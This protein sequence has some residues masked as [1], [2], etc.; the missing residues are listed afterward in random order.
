VG[1]AADVSVHA[2]GGV[3]LSAEAA[4]WPSAGARHE[5]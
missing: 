4:C 1:F 5:L 2:T 3:E